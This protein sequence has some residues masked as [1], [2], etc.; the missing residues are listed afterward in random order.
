MIFI[1]IAILALSIILAFR[2]MVDFDV[3]AEIKRLLNGKRVRGTIV[4]FKNKVKHYSSDSSSSSS[5]S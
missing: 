3:P 4:F 2:S 5:G 1:F